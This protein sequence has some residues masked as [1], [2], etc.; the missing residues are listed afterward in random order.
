MNLVQ[1]FVMLVFH[2]LCADAIHDKGVDKW[3]L[4]REMFPKI[5]VFVR[6]NFCSSH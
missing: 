1:D 2:I 6:L 3:C 5:S 4:C